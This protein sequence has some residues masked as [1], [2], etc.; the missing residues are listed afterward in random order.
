MIK[1]HL[2]RTKPFAD[3]DEVLKSTK[4]QNLKQ[5]HVQ[6]ITLWYIGRLTKPQARTR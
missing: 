3:D 6:D 2:K 4:D 5:N 1:Q